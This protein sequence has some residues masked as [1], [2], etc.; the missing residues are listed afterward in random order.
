MRRLFA[1]HTKTA[2]AAIILFSEINTD[3]SGVR[4]IEATY[5]DCTA[6]DNSFGFVNFVGAETQFAGTA[7]ELHKRGSKDLR[8]QDNW[9]N[10]ENYRRSNN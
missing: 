3:A 7:I 8:Q 1:A 5:I 9:W 10:F 2:K 4:T 6:G